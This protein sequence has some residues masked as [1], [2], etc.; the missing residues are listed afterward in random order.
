MKVKSSNYLVSTRDFF[1]RVSNLWAPIED[2]FFVTK[3]RLILV[4]SLFL[5]LFLYQIN[6][7]D[8]FNISAKKVQKQNDIKTPTNLISSVLISLNWEEKKKTYINS[9]RRGKIFRWRLWYILAGSLAPLIQCKFIFIVLSFE[10][11]CGGCIVFREICLHLYILILKIM[12]LCND[13]C[14]YSRMTIWFYWAI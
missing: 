13:W 12:K 4:M 1:T 14:C 10:P 8:I 6:F 9:D 11:F 2:T 5:S 3:S 7:C